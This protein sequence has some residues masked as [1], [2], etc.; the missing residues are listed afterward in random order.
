MMICDRDLNDM[1]IIDIY[2]LNNKRNTLK[3]ASAQQNIIY[4]SQQYVVD[5]ICTYRN[6][7]LGRF[8]HI[9]SS[10]LVSV[11]THYNKPQAVYGE[12]SRCFRSVSMKLPRLRFDF[13]ERVRR[14]PDERS[15]PSLPPRQKKTVA[16]K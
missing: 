5:I 6:T 16:R 10:R 15:P 8:L 11:P 12:Y 13:V 14:T 9:V 3:G 1:T 2:K 4:T 7:L